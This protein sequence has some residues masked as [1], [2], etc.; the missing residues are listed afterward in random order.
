MQGEATCEPAFDPRAYLRARDIEVKT[1]SI[2]ANEDEAGD[3]LLTV[4][5]RNRADLLVMGAFSKRRFN[6]WALGGT[7]RH[8][9][10]YA[11]LPLFMAH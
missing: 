5:S 2:E 10:Q 9:L 4:A 8:V 1:E 6:E 3:T 11:S 7:T